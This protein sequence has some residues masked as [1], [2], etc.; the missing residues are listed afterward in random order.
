MVVAI[1]RSRPKQ[2]LTFPGSSTSQQDGGTRA[3]PHSEQNSR[4]IVMA[5]GWQRIVARRGWSFR[6]HGE[7]L[8]SDGDYRVPVQELPGG[9]FRKKGRTSIVR[10]LPSPRTT[11]P[12]F[13]HHNLTPVP[14]SVSARLRTVGVYATFNA[15]Q[16][17]VKT[18]E[19]TG[20]MNNLITVLLPFVCMSAAFVFTTSS[21]VVQADGC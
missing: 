6:A 13:F 16:F 5:V 21:S 1:T 12:P 8:E 11:F 20:D 14:S 3:A 9:E 10:R 19:R 17:Q 2:N 7:R 4:R 15:K 18:V